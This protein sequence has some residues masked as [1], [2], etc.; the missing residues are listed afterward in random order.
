MFCTSA[1]SQLS[2]GPA[3]GGASGNRTYDNASAPAR[4]GNSNPASGRADIFSAPTGR[5]SEGGSRSRTAEAANSQRQ[6]SH[7]G[8]PG[9]NCK[10]KSGADM[11]CTSALNQL[12]SRPSGWAGWNRTI[13]NAHAPARAGNSNAVP[14]A[15]GVIAGRFPPPLR[16]KTGHSA[17]CPGIASG[18]KPVCN[19]GGLRPST[20]RP[21]RHVTFKGMFARTVTG[22]LRLPKKVTFELRPARPV[23]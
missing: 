1:L 15:R 17:N 3:I 4:A 8:P 18:P 2:N 6:S 20:P 21:G 23:S 10:P 5:G 16:S 22:R 12:S 14:P 13:G 7:P 19:C 9:P 11:L